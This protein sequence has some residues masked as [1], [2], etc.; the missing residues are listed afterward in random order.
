M[1]VCACAISIQDTPSP[2]TILAISVKTDLAIVKLL[3]L[4]TNTKRKEVNIVVTQIQQY[5]A[6]LHQI[7]FRYI[8]SQI[9]L[10]NIA[11]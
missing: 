11:V 1:Y 10:P 4:L 7:R 3:I 2:K 9:P 5:P 8:V 6:T